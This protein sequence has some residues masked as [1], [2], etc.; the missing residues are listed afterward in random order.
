V[1]VI[2]AIDGGSSSHLLNTDPYLIT[3]VSW[4]EI[5]IDG[6]LVPDRSFDEVQ[7][8]NKT[9][10]SH[11]VDSPQ[12]SRFPLALRVIIFDMDQ[13]YAVL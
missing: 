4:T 8:A 7:M 13:K 2:V 11:D 9:S 10:N 12:S 1:K 6:P 3:E 5:H